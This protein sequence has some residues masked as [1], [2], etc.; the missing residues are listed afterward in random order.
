MDYKN[1]YI[2]YKTKY[3][4]LKNNNLIGGSKHFNIDYINNIIEDLKIK[5]YN[6]N[7]IMACILKKIMN[8]FKITKEQYMV[9]A[10]YCLHKYKEV[11]DL[12]I[13]IQKGIP[14][15]KLRNSGLFEID[16]A[17]ISGDERL[18]LKLARIDKDAEIEFFPKLRKIGFP[19]N[20]YSLKNL[21]LKKLLS[22]DDYDN[23]YFNEITCAKLYSNIIRKNDNKYY[24]YE[25]EISKERVEKNISHLKFILNNTLDKKIIKYCKK[26]IIFLENIDANN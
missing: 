26:K 7:M 11:T 16:I 10:G 6:K 24:T 20:Y 12:D 13:V 17:K 25:Y 23:P 19:S 3:L 21:Q 8:E 22:Y 5:G 1:K 4:E 2:K 9:I 14:Y 15:N 18:V